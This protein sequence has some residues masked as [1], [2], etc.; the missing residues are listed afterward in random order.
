MSLG[1]NRNLGASAK[2][3]FRVEHS[4]GGA[5][6]ELSLNSGIAWRRAFENIL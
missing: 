6:R 1:A 4:M 2:V 3:Y 5:L